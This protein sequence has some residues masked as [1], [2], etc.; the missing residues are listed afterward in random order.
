M[1]GDAPERCLGR[2][3]VV[4]VGNSQRADDG[5]GVFIAQTL[6]AA[7][8]EDVIVADTTPER[9]MTTL[10]A[11]AYDTLLFVDAVS[12][13]AEPGAAVLMDAAE[14]QS[15]FPQVSTHR[16]SLGTLARLV[17]SESG[18]RVFLLGVRPGSL[19]QQPGLSP[20]VE[21]TARCLAEIL[22]EAL[23]GQPT[24]ALRPRSARAAACQTDVQ[25]ALL[26]C[27]A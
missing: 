20:A 13:P 19:G 12:V 16:I 7:G 14:I 18:A 5:A 22:A 6:Q 9:W 23:T 21:K 1:A 27:E 17:A 26:E 15:Q 11:G 25:P 8:L 10:T 3:C 24:A 4:G 2:V